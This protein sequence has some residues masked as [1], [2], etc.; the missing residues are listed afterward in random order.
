MRHY[1]R[2]HPYSRIP[3]SPEPQIAPPI[4]RNPTAIDSEQHSQCHPVPL[5]QG[6]PPAPSISISDNPG[7]CEQ[8]PDIDEEGLAELQYEPQIQISESDMEG[9]E[10]QGLRG[11]D[12]ELVDD[13]SDSDDE[14]IWR[15]EDIAEEELLFADIDF[16][17]YVAEESSQSQESELS[18]SQ[19]RQECYPRPCGTAIEPAEAVANSDRDLLS[20]PWSPF[21]SSEDYALA[22]WFVLSGT[23]KSMISKFFNEGL[24]GARKHSFTSAATLWNQLDRMKEHL[25]RWTKGTV[26]SRPN[27]RRFYYRDPIAVIR[28]LLRQTAYKGHLKFAPFRRY[29]PINQRRQYTDLWDSDWT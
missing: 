15:R 25:P 19:N 8:L 4:P 16:R 26:G 23:P 18:D 9:E 12:S 20:D 22:R 5:P 6:E 7:S 13:F 3:T 27:Q 1:Q 14:D 29:S 10:F 28:Y 24:V 17:H 21:I 2:Y 11:R